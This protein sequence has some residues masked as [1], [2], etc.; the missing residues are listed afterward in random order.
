VRSHD[1]YGRRVGKRGGGRLARA[2]TAAM[3][4]LRQPGN[5]RKSAI[6]AV[7]NRANPCY[8]VCD[9]TTPCRDLSI[10]TYCTPEVYEQ[11]DKYRESERERKRERVRER[12]K[13][14][15]RERERERESDR[16][17]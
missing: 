10:K 7:E 15:E 17:K 9:A 12:K 5:R 14:R 1:T 4:A 3:V 11:M 16:Y 6:F 8:L 13:E 2:P